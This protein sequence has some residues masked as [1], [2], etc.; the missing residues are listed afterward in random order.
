MS[1]QPI[2]NEIHTQGIFQKPFY[3]HFLKGSWSDFWSLTSMNSFMHQTTI[4]LY[5]DF[6]VIIARNLDFQMNEL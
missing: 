3:F 4:W 1:T 6:D 5:L 2:F